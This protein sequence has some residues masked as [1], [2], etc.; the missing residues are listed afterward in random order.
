MLI[1]A[2]QTKTCSLDPIPTFFLK[3]IVEALLPSITLLV[4]GSLAQATLPKTQ[5]SSIITPILKK[6]N[7]DPNDMSHYRPISNLSFLSKIVERVVASQLQLHLDQHHLLPRSQSAYRPCHSTETALM[8]V[9]SD[10]FAAADRQHITILTL[11]DLTAAFDCV[12]HGILL[13]R[14]ESSFGLT[15]RALG[16]F[17]SY[18]ADRTSHVIYDSI[19]SH[20]C[21]V[22][23]GVP[24]GSILGPILFTMYI[25]DLERVVADSGL[26]AHFYADDSQLYLSCPPIDI[27]TCALQVAECTAQVERW[28]HR[29]RLKLNTSKT[30]VICLGTR[31]QISRVSPE[32]FDLGSAVVDRTRTTRDLGFT[33]DEHLT[34]SAHIL[35]VVRSSFH[36]LRQIRT[37]IGSLTSTAAATMIHAFVSSRLDYCNGLLQGVASSELARLQSAQNAAARL[38]TGTRR[39]DHITPILRDLHWLPITQR[40]QFKTV[41]TVFKSLHGL[42]PPYLAELCIPLRNTK[43]PSSLRS[44]DTNQLHVPRTR[45]VFGSRSFAVAGPAAWNRLPPHLR[46]QPLSL[47]T[48][49]RRLKSHYFTD[50][51][52]AHS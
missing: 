29:N 45:T 13:R 42:A 36:Q 20:T 12:D 43:R 11:L 40:V 34:M 19:A 41:F 5:K 37:V 52:A 27:A 50:T 51:A 28:L 18:L 23:C 26:E 30:E 16:S 32:T 14:L 39:C 6:M 9:L 33:I 15:E 17:R 31:Q 8:K 10:V 44:N 25:A 21:P 7:L 46:D 1:M 49:A 4:N 35:T 22:T 48:F 3:E 38:I 24:Q 47:S 2:A